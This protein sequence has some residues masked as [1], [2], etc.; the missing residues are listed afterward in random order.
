[1]SSLLNLF[2]LNVLL[3]TFRIRISLSILIGSWVKNSGARPGLWEIRALNSNMFKQK[4]YRQSKVWD[5]WQKH[6][7]LL[8]TAISDEKLH[9]INTIRALKKRIYNFVEGWARQEYRCNVLAA[10]AEL[11]VWGANHS[12]CKQVQYANLIK[13]ACVSSRSLLRVG[14]LILLAATCPSIPGQ[15]LTLESKSGR[16]YRQSVSNTK[17]Q[18]HRPFAKRKD[19]QEG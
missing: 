16:L 19:S 4:L 18:S 12:K 5:G 11:L 8:A 13:S 3:F 1:M 2:L 9:P 17:P 7:K 14:L 6:Q 15:E 10:I